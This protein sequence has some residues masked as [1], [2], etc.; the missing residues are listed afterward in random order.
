MDGFNNGRRIY[1]VSKKLARNR[2]DK[3][4][5]WAILLEP[6]KDV[7]TTCEPYD[8]IGMRPIAAH[9]GYEIRRFVAAIL[10]LTM[11]KASSVDVL[12]R[13]INKTLERAHT[14][15]MRTTTTSVFK[16]GKYRRQ[17]MDSWPTSTIANQ[18]RIC[19]H[20]GYLRF[21]CY[22]MPWRRV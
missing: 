17:G 22:H 18:R 4:Y 19:E 3:P 1:L 10:F 6:L 5:V 8:Y 12:C 7:Y 16:A 13:V 14:M 21:F 2:L 15:K 20:R 11:N 9:V